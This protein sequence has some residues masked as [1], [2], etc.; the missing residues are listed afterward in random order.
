MC[1]SGQLE[2]NFRNYLRLTGAQMD[3]EQFKEIYGWRPDGRGASIPRAVDR[4]FDQP[5]SP[6][7]QR[8]HQLIVAQRAATI[9]ALEQDLFAQ[10]KRLADAE[11]KLAVKATKAASE[12]RR[13]AIDKVEK[14][15]RRLGVLNDPKPR[16]SDG[17]FFPMHHVPL[18][19]S[20]GGRKV[21]RLARY[22]C[23]LAGKPAAVDR[24]FPGLY[25]ARRD[26]IERYWK[27]A[28]GVTHGLL[29]LNS[30]FENV[31]RGGRNAVLHFIPKPAD[32][33][34][35]A[36]VYSVWKDPQGGP[37]LLSF[38]AIT[39]E[40]PPEVAAAGHDRMIINIKPENIDRWLNPQ[41]RS[42]EELQAILSDRQMPYYD[43][44]V[45][46]A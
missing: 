19:V 34:L 25:N 13:I 24:Q 15:V 26:N 11:R 42:I 31:D 29:L 28:F 37:D 44:E 43:Y 38:A 40:P 27:S 7:E 14:I 22:H 3:I 20:D 5:Q 2:A 39:D 36:C 33:M 1:Y 12:G 6:D 46:A 8:I 4:W 45:L 21:I 18:I 16:D 10:R 30:F 23:R 9:S 41:G 32:T 17:R 35:V